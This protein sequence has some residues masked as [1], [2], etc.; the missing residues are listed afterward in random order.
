MIGIVEAGVANVV[1]AVTVETV[2]NGALKNG[3]TV[4]GAGSRVNEAAPKNREVG[5]R[6]VAVAVVVGVAVAVAARGVETVGR[7][8]SIVPEAT[9][10]SVAVALVIA[11]LP[12]PDPPLDAKQVRDLGR[13]RRETES[14]V[15]RKVRKWKQGIEVVLSIIKARS[16]ASARTAH[17]I[18]YTTTERRRRASTRS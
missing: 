11:T 2:P 18:F 10:V 8:R 13:H 14:M 7:S 4:P 9:A 15:L 12:D 6:A 16:L 5:L 3:T 17:T 1:E